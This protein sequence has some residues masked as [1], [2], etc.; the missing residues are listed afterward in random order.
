MTMKI[1]I[2]GKEI[3]FEENRTI[4]E[5]ARDNN[6]YIPALCYHKKTGPA[7]ACRICVVEVEGM[8]GLQT[9]CTVKAQDG[10]K[11]MT[12]TPK[13]V[14]ARRL[15]VNL[16]L[17]TCAKNGCESC[18]ADGECELQ[19]TANKLGIKKPE[20]FVDHETEPAD[21]SSEMIER[22]FGRCIE[23]G[24]CI[25]GCNETVVNEVL[26]FGY[27]AKNVK[28]VCDSDLPMGDSSCVQCGECSQLCP[29]G[30]ILDKKAVGKGRK[31]LK[32][33]DTVCPYC[34][35]GCQISLHVDEKENKI[36][37]IT[38]VE[39][40]PTNDGMLCV[41]G[42]F[43]FD[44]VNSPERLTKPLVKSSEGEFK[45]ISW[46]EAINIVSQKFKEIKEKYGSDS[47][48][49]LSSAKVTNEDNYLFQKLMRKEVGTNN[50][51]HCA[52]L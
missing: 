7:G 36:I 9:A 45:E 18:D 43:G 50:V 35:V 26:E 41:K 24:R 32:R 38:G 28:V 6:I 22:N 15:I 52:R 48:A 5:I 49:G 25:R 20:F 23:C 4:L 8:R 16:L 37:K 31:K 51:D 40:S 12:N 34:G 42:R 13:L 39:E 44:F 10:M 46:N 3:N 14:E 47:I 33:V 19:E 11:V 30:S 17:S 2:D 21:V 27:R 29:V 1:T